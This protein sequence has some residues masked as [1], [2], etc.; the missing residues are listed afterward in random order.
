MHADRSALIGRYPR[1]LVAWCAVGLLTVAY[2]LSFVD[3]QIMSLLVAPIRR[4][5]DIS[6]T[7]M[8]LLMGFSFAVFYTLC[9]IPLGRLTDVASRRWIVTL[10]V[11]FWSAATMA[12]GLAAHYWHLF[13][14]RVGVGIGE[15]A[16]SPAAFSLIADS[17]PPE[18]RGTATSVYGT[19]IFIGSGLAYVVGGVVIGLV[20]ARGETVL[21]LVGATRPWQMVF[22]VLGGAGLLFA[23]FLLLI[24]EP[25]RH[26]ASASAPAI[27]F[28]DVVAMLSRHRK[29]VLLHNFGFGGTALALY[30]INAWL[31]SVWQRVHGWEIRDVGIV[32]GAIV[33]LMGGLG[34]VLGGWLA[35]RWKAR[36]MSDATLRVGAIAGACGAPLSLGIA[37][38]PNGV[39]LAALMVPLI[40]FVAM[41]L[42]VAAS[43]IQDLVPNGMRGQTSAI[44]L[45][46]VNLVGLGIGPTAVALLTDRV[47]H[48]DRSVHLSLAIVAAVAQA[49]AFL[50]LTRGRA[51]YRLSLTQ[52]EGRS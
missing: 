2:V 14:G 31:P 50:L 5:L 12:C 25:M 27:A 47:F 46:V 35:D 36:G 48:D 19:G 41:P 21:P 44:Y 28:R 23:W 29:T 17:F 52:I 42:G 43:A 49:G 34:I 45:F 24:R 20:A 6:D 7:Q 16:L 11:A 30:S 40:V 1:P 8:S 22:Y 51:H 3:R 9:G 4:D 18:R 38:A 26:G 10:G 15:A 33:A 13:L 32:Y 39:A 37:L